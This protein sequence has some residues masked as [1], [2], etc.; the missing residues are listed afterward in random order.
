MGRGNRGRVSRNFS[1]RASA[2][3]LTRARNQSRAGWP[4]AFVD[5]RVFAGELVFPTQLARHLRQRFRHF[6]S[7]HFESAT[8]D[9]WIVF[10]QFP[11]RSVLVL[12]RMQ[13]T[14]RVA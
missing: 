3:L 14:A 6:A 8:M 2:T 5:D 7:E 12:R 13:R 4:V 1:A 9:H 11:C 10:D